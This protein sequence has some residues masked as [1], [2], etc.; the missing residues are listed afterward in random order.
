MA[1]N[2]HHAFVALSMCLEQCF[3]TFFPIPSYH[4]PKFSIPPLIDVARNLQWG[5]ADYGGLLAVWKREVLTSRMLGVK[6]SNL[7]CR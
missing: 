4:T 6:P 3:S 2:R 7:I 5:G 1:I